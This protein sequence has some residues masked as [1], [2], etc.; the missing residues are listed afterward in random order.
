M[1]WS[2]SHSQRL[3]DRCR[4][5]RFIFFMNCD[6]VDQVSHCRFTFDLQKLAL[7]NSMK[8]GWTVDTIMIVVSGHMHVTLKYAESIN[9]LASRDVASWEWGQ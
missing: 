5:T 9:E 8:I 1:A 2:A 3:S 7:A 6:Q 4:A